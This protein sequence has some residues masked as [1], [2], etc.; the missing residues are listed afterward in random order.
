MVD[1]EDLGDL[2]LSG[3]RLANEV[4]PVASAFEHLRDDLA[5]V[6]QI[7]WFVMIV[8]SSPAVS[9]SHQTVAAGSAARGTTVSIPKVDSLRHKPVEVG[10]WNQL[11]ILFYFF[12]TLS[13]AG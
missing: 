11:K 5:P 4:S 2:G 3:L 9:P 8:A 12:T 1:C 7:H 10:S 6:L 13:P